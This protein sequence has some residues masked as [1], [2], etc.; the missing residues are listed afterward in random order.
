LGLILGGVGYLLVVE[1]RILQVQESMMYTIVGFGVLFILC[2]YVILLTY[3]FPIYVHFILRLTEYLKW[4]LIIV[5]I[6]SLLCMFLLSL[7][8]VGIYV[9]L[10][11]VLAI[12]F[13]FGVSTAS[14]IIMCDV[15]KTFDKY[16]LR[17]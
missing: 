4:P 6:Y 3:F 13:F 15:S 9:L 16:E 8:C 2:M 11:T 10:M 14:Y 12:F 1:F 17:E 5:I 7:L